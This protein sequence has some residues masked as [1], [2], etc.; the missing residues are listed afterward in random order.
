[1]INKNLNSASI[2][3][4]DLM[5]PSQNTTWDEATFT[6]DEAQGTW[7]DVWAI[8]NKAIHTASVTNKPIS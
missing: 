8:R 3:N 5:A 1:M 7:D 2:T 6:W 4:K